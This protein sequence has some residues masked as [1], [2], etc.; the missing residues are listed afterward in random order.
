MSRG[1][2]SLQNCNFAMVL[3]GLSVCGLCMF[4]DVSWGISME[5]QQKINALQA[6]ITTIEM[7]LPPQENSPAAQ[8]MITQA[9]KDIAL[10]TYHVSLLNPKIIKLQPAVDEY[11]ELIQ[12]KTA[13]KA[14]MG[15]LEK[16]KTTL[17]TRLKKRED[18]VK[19]IDE[20]NRQ[21]AELMK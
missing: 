4:G 16:E 5:T 11:N 7:T 3:L 1:Y 21:I 2:L 8:V 17:R 6:Q 20:L 19:Q 15:T 18:G 12:A 10:M 13:L 9:D 14:S